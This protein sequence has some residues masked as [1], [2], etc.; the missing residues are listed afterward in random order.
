MEQ[1]DDEVMGQ[2][3]AAEAAVRQAAAEGLTLQ[4]SGNAAGYRCVSKECRK[5]LAKPFSA[6][7]MRAG[8]EV[9][10]GH[11]ATAEEAALAYART[12]EAQAQVAQR[13]DKGQVAARRLLDVANKLEHRSKHNTAGSKR[14]RME[15][16]EKAE[17]KAEQAEARAMELGLARTSSQGIKLTLNDQGTG[18]K[19]VTCRKTGGSKRFQALYVTKTNGVVAPTFRGVVRASAV[20]A[21]V[22]VAK[23]FAGE[24]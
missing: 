18:Y 17:A 20:E 6:S 8:K 14:K 4:P 13:Q 1:D 3:D 12:P 22:D 10:L 15:R 19:H 2:A 9:R 23:Y 5:A 11:F 24:V 16:A 21:A 7:V